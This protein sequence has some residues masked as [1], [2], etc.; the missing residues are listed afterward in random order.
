MA[1]AEMTDVEAVAE[2][3][4]LRCLKEVVTDTD[5]EHGHL[6][7]LSSKWEASIYEVA[8]R[9]LLVAVGLFHG[10]NRTEHWWREVDIDDTHI[11]YLGASTD[12]RRSMIRAAQAM[13]EKG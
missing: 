10:G 11:R 9:K 6:G 5:D 8:L 3:R 13:E 7:L 2:F 12:Y 4:K 1:D